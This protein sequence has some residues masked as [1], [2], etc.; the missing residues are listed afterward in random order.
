MVLF[1][2]W[3]INGIN[4]AIDTI[5]NIPGVS[6]GR[7]NTISLPR[8]AEGGFPQTGSLF[9]ANEAGPE[10]VG[11][12]N[13]QTAVANSDQISEGVRIAAYQGMK[14]AL[15]EAGLSPKIYVN[16]GNEKVY[17]GYGK[18]KKSDSNMYGV[19]V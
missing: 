8:F 14:Q 6:I 9:I 5:N 15:S 12:M 13:G 11:S 19:E 10:W 1:L 4:S 3:F 7:I 2:K 17:S 18:Q 16:I